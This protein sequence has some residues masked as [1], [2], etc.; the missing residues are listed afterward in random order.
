VL[1]LIFQTLRSAGGEDGFT[2][3]FQAT[4]AAAGG[5]AATMTVVQGWS[6]LRTR[7]D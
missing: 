7:R 4:F 3:A 5:V 6:A 2:G 1:M